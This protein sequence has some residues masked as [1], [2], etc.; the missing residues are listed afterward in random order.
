MQPAGAG[1]LQLPCRQPAV[2]KP[3]S[4]NL[5]RR[6]N[7]PLRAVLAGAAAMAPVYHFLRVWEC[8]IREPAG[9]SGEPR[10]K[11][12]ERRRDLANRRRD[13]ANRT[14]QAATGKAHGRHAGPDEAGRQATAQ[15]AGQAF[16][17][18]SADR[19]CGFT[20]N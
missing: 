2:L 16:T 13:P 19:A 6:V 8:F 10:R 18:R 15:N 14:R 20:T 9:Q 4:I 5:W 7:P 3:T 1:P 12:A 17:A 11:H